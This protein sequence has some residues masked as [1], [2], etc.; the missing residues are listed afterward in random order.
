[1]KTIISSMLTVII[2]VLMIWILISWAN[3]LCHN[4]YGADGEPADWNAFMI[5]TEAMR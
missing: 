2:V 4:G 1:M 3:V 5:M